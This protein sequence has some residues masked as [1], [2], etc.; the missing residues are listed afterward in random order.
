MARLVKLEPRD[1]GDDK[2]R[3][4]GRLK[5]RQQT[6]LYSLI[7]ERSKRGLWT[8][9]EDAQKIGII[10]PDKRMTDIKRACPDA[11]QVQRVGRRV[12]F[13]V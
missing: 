3:N 12:E 10:C 8:T 13:C 5:T 11:V 1:I 4:L 7:V 2:Y 9:Y 6:E